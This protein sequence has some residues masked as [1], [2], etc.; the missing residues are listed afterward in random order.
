MIAS[1]TIEEINMKARKSLA[2]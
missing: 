2:R 1:I